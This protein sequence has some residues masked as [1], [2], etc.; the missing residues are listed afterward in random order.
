MIT[1]GTLFIFMKKLTIDIFSFS[2]ISQVN[3]KMNLKWFEKD[4]VNITRKA[5]LAR[6]GEHMLGTFYIMLWCKVVPSV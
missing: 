5:V 6:R 1:A 3:A 2:F 4:V